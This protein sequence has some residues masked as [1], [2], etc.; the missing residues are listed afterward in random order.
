MRQDNA[1]LARSGKE[2]ATVERGQTCEMLDLIARLQIVL[3]HADID[4]GC[5]ELLR[6]ALQRF[7]DL[8]TQ[9]L[10]RRS[11]LRARGH[12]D[13]IVAILALLSELNQL[14]ESEKDRTVF[15]EMALLFD[16]I[17]RSAAAGA[18]ALR[19]IDPPGASRSH[20]ELAFTIGT[21]RQ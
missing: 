17:G 4:C 14:T 16:E 7:S 11:L 18:A 19:D 5:R 2:A 20:D 6:G 21:I 8:E 1:M 12:K 3:M 15:V 13:R 10:S 9:R